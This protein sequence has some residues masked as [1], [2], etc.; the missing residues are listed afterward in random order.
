MENKGRRILS[1]IITVVIVLV[2]AFFTFPTLSSKTGASKSATRTS[3]KFP[4]GSTS[5]AR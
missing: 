3:E 5:D 2:F 4:S 1:G